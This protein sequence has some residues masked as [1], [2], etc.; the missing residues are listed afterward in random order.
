MFYIKNRFKN[1]SVIYPGMSFI[2][3]MYFVIVGRI[4]FFVSRLKTLLYLFFGFFPY[5]TKINGKRILDEFMSK[6]GAVF[7]SVHSGSYPLAGKIFYDNYPGH[8]IITPFYKFNKYSA[9]GI[10]K[11]LFKKININIV[12]LGGA[13]KEIQP[14]LTSGGS[15]CLFLDAVL[16]VKNWVKVKIFNKDISLSTGPLWLSKKFSKPVIPIYVQDKGHEIILNV[17]PEIK[18]VG[19]NNDL[20]MK[21][22]T[23]SIEKMIL[24]TIKQWHIAD[25]FLFQD[26]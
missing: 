15:V 19:K 6:N 17:L 10:Y 21:E 12:Q 24:L 20:I 9:Y 3:I 7:I 18:I 26:L 13:M 23:N 11:K 4:N 5:K 2:K 8:K 14:V 16:P 25:N 1:I 22:I